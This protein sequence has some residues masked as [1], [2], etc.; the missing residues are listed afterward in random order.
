MGVRGRP[1]CGDPDDRIGD[2]RARDGHPQG[3]H[4]TPGDLSEEDERPLFAVAQRT[5]AAIRQSGLRC[6]G[7][8]FFLADGEAAFQEIPRLHLHVFP[9][10]DADPFKL[11]ADGD[12]KPERQELDANPKRI[13]EAFVRL[14]GA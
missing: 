3:P 13:R 1:R 7:I 5:E 10:F 14:H 12:V 2:A 4:P 6:E 9:R 11:V 8:S